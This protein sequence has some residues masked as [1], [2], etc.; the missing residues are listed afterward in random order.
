VVSKDV[1]AAKIVNRDQTAS[2]DEMGGDPSC[3]LHLFCSECG[4]QLD[5]TA[6]HSGCTAQAPNDLAR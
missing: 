5:G 1:D 4:V 6:H 3:W 2:P